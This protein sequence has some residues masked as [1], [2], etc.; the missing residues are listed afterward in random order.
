MIA[1]HVA[2]IGPMCVR[3]DEVPAATL[4][5]ER[6]V[7]RNQ[8][9][10][11]GKPEAMVEKIVEG[12]VNK[13]YAEVCLLEQPFVQDDKKKVEQVVTEAGAKC[14]GLKLLRFVRFQLGETA[15]AEEVAE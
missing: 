11:E 1:M 14:G 8:T 5:N 15:T 9:I 13:Y 6:G 3:R 10:N 12:R 2:A 4:E 7:Y